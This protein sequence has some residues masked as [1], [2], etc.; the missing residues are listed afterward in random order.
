MCERLKA[1]I[2]RE[3]LPEVEAAIDELFEAIAGA[4]RADSGQKEQ[5]E[6]MQAFKEEIEALYADLRTGELGQEECEAI[7]RELLELMEEADV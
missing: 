6:Q 2:E 3:M 1:L 5:F 7:Y 4:K